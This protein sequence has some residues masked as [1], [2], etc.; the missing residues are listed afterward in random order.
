R[1]DGR[2]AARAVR[3]RTKRQKAKGKRQ[4][5]K[6]RTTF[7]PPLLPFA[8]C[9]LPSH[10]GGRICVFLKHLARPTES[11]RLLACSPHFCYNKRSIWHSIHWA[12]NHQ[13]EDECPA[14]GV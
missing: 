14:E 10:Q 8:F 2:R 7:T 11:G 12:R 9:L 3:T 4:K 5:L 1:R 6:E 13:S